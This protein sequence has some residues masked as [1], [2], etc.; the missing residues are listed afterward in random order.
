V[1][2]DE[3]LLLTVGDGGRGPKLDQGETR[4]TLRVRS[5]VR[6]QVA[7]HERPGRLTREVTWSHHGPC[8]NSQHS[9]HTSGET[10]DPAATSERGEPEVTHV[11]VGY[12]LY[13]FS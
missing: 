11:H 9:R 5:Q 12:T 1:N 4:V 2:R 8:V 7:T 10:D 3:R 13:G 6:C